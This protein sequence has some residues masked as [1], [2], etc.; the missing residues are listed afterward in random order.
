MLLLLPMLIVWFTK[1][2]SLADLHEQTFTQI[3]FREWKHATGAKAA[4]SIHH[5]CLL[6]KESVVAWKQFKASSKS[7]S[8]ADQLST[9]RAEQK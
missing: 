7:G 9:L 3:G 6:H 8:V 2:T 4:L 5:N 1:Y